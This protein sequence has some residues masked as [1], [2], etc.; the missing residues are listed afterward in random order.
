MEHRN[1]IAPRSIALCNRKS[2][3]TGLLSLLYACVWTTTHAQDPRSNDPSYELIYKVN[4][5]CA[6]TVQLM[7]HP[8]S[9]RTTWI[10]KT[11]CPV[12]LGFGENFQPGK[13]LMVVENN[14]MTLLMGY[15]RDKILDFKPEEQQVVSPYGSYRV[16]LKEETLLFEKWRTWTFVFKLNETSGATVILRLND[17]LGILSI[18]NMDRQ[19][20]IVGQIELVKVNRKPIAQFVKESDIR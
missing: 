11:E 8:T 14:Q 1:L 10:S 9:F 16:K 2:W 19:R 20:N 5:K 12:Q 3:I 18:Q 6:D 7:R 15:H 4:G 17:V 13:H